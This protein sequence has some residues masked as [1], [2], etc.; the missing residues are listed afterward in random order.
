MKFTVSLQFHFYV[1]LILPKHA[2]FQISVV[3]INNVTVWAI[4]IILLIL[5]ITRHTELLSIYFAWKIGLNDPF[6]SSLLQ[7]STLP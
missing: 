6:F 2:M 4:V 5:K 1:I 3:K 7:Y